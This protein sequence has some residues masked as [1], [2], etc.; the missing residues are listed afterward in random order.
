MNKLKKVI[1]LSFLFYFNI[2]LLFLGLTPCSLKKEAHFYHE[3]TV[4]TSYSWGGII[5]YRSSFK[6]YLLVNGFRV[7]AYFIVKSKLSL[8]LC[9][10]TFRIAF[11][12][13]LFIV[14]VFPIC[15]S[16]PVFLFFPFSPS[17]S[18]HKKI[19]RSDW[20]QYN[21]HDRRIIK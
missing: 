5:F 1:F 8:R 14:L 2:F 6:L 17:F 16:L 13:S 15:L 19:I 4:F 20:S 9:Y 3:I 12:F 21:C 11:I 7:Y 18:F 10:V